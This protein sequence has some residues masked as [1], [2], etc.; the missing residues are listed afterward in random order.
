MKNKTNLQIMNEFKRYV[1]SYIE[2]YKESYLSKY[3]HETIIEDMIYGIGKCIDEKEYVF[4]NGYEKF[5][6]KLME[7][8]KKYK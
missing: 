3:T 4:A 7:I 1:D 6:E 8:F 2:H 5:R